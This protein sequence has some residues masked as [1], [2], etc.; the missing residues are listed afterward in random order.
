MVPSLIF[1]TLLIGGLLAMY[2]PFRLIQGVEVDRLVHHARYLHELHRCLVDKDAV[3]VKEPRVK[4]GRFLNIIKSRSIYSVLTPSEVSLLSLDN[5]D[6][7]NC[8]VKEV[9]RLAALI[10]EEITA[11][12][13]ERLISLCRELPVNCDMYFRRPDR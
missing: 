5:A 3:E 6:E 12:K 8:K 7:Y 4:L 2:I 9:N 10:N 11:E 1:A 13:G